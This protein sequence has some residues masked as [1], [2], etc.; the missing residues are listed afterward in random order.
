[1]VERTNERTNERM[2]EQGDSRSR[3]KQHFYFDKIR[4]LRASYCKKTFSAKPQSL[5]RPLRLFK[6]V[7]N[8]SFILEHSKNMFPKPISQLV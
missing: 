7:E 1:M 3:M 8:K 4:M 6:V 2:N 5:V